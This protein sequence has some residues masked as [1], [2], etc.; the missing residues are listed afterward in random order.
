MVSGVLVQLEVRGAWAGGLRCGVGGAVGGR[1]GG[2][3]AAQSPPVDCRGCKPGVPQCGVIDINSQNNSNTYC[4]LVHVYQTLC[5]VHGQLEQAIKL[6]VIA[7]S[8]LPEHLRKTKT[9]CKDGIRVV[10]NRNQRQFQNGS[11][12]LF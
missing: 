10:Q 6:L 12:N 2:S 5:D 8:E 9:H 11:C 1:G 4:T 7:P 3:S